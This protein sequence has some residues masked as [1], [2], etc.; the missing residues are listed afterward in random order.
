MQ[1]HQ[2]AA[3]AL[4]V[5][6]LSLPVTVPH[7]H[8]SDALVPQ[9]QTSTAS[10]SII[11]A[12]TAQAAADTDIGEPPSIPSPTPQVENIVVTLP[13]T[14]PTPKPVQKTAQKKTKTVNHTVTQEKAQIS[15]PK[16]REAN[17]VV[18]IGKSNEQCVIYAR[19]ITGNA[20]VRGYA[21]N[22]KSEGSEPK[23]GAIAL[24]KS[25]GHVSIVIAINGD[26]LILHDSNWKKGSITER[27]VH[28]ST[29]RGYIY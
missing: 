7:K 10:P 8:H 5:T 4:L 29:Q 12:E 6:N 24:E 26:Y 20:K 16:Q 11:P 27:R 15:Q 19:R 22:L 14:T 13:P 23:V 2:A 3:W 25:V 21:G 1:L 17:S 18:V 9:P 28:K